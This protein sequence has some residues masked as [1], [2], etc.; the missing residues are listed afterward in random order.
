MEKL[1][2]RSVIKYVYKK[3]CVAAFKR[4]HTIIED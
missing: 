3:D 1:D 4:V 2:I